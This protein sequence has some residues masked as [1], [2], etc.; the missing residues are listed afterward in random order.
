MNR[1]L[2]TRLILL[3][4]LIIMA[5]ANKEH[6]HGHEHNR[7]EWSQFVG[8]EGGIAE[9][10]IKKERPELLVVKVPHVSPSTAGFWNYSDHRAMCS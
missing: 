4:V 3:F 2:F 5:S 8:Q 6:L 9:E 7:N 1:R 10:M